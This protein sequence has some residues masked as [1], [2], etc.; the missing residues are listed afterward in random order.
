MAEAAAHRSD[1]HRDEAEEPLGDAAAVHQPPGE[2]EE[3]DGE[4]QEVAHLVDRGPR[5]QRRDARVEEV[6]EEPGG[7]A[8][9]RDAGGEADGHPEADERE[10]ER[11]GD[12]GG[13]HRACPR[14]CSRTRAAR[15]P[16]TKTM[17]ETIATISTAKTCCTRIHG[18]VT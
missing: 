8:E 10:R 13:D 2:E 16:I 5:Q 17:I 6:A 1:E 7:A 15:S 9:A 11:E 12:A 14:R 18:T 4:E 3:G